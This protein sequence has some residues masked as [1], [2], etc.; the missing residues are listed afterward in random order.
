MG[1]MEAKAAVDLIGQPVPGDIPDD[2]ICPYLKAPIG[3][4]QDEG[5]VV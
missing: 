1:L 2:Q 5:S 4:F 3:Q